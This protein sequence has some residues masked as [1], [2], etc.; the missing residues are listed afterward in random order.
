VPHRTATQDWVLWDVEVV[1]LLTPAPRPERTGS[2][3][4]AKLPDSRPAPDLGKPPQ[5]HG[6]HHR[7]S[8]S[9]ATPPPMLEPEAPPPP[10]SR[11]NKLEVSARFSPLR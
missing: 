10:L 3:P 2:A 8:K 5:A 6:S 4:V 7:P 11:F 1:Q 9:Y